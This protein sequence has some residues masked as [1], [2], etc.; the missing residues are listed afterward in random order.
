MTLDGLTSRAGD[1]NARAALSAWRER[2]VR[3]SGWRLGMLRRLW[4]KFVLWLLKDID[5]G[6]CGGKRTDT[7]YE[8][9]ESGSRYDAGGDAGISL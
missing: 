6:R 3:P 9:R 1:L 5:A 8:T 2:P 4:D 7:H